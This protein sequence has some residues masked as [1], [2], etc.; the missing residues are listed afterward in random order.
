[1]HLS[2]KGQ[3]TSW[4]YASCTVSKWR[5]LLYHINIIWGNAIKEKQMKEM[6][7]TGRLSLFVNRL[8]KREIINLILYIF[9]FRM[10]RYNFYIAS[11]NMII[12]LKILH[13]LLTVQLAYAQE[14]RCPLRP[15][16]MWLTRC[17]YFGRIRRLFEVDYRKPIEY[18]LMCISQRHWEYI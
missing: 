16:C 18:N 3:Q 4:A 7:V 10:F 1:M 15:K 2:L 11:Y 9:I 17:S 5:K 6:I 12:R 14:V 13:H 8:S